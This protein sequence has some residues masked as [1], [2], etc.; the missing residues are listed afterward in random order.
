MFITRVV[1]SLAIL[2]GASAFA[3]DVVPNEK[4]GKLQV[5]APDVSKLDPK[6]DLSSYG[7]TF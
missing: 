2:S 7:I 4:L 5:D 6:F 1:M 3:K